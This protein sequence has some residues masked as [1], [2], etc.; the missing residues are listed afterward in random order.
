MSPAKTTQKEK[1]ERSK[2]RSS[3]ESHRQ[4]VENQNSKEKRANQP[5]WAN[6]Q[7]KCAIQLYAINKEKNRKNSIVYFGCVCVCDLPPVRHPF[8]HILPC[9]SYLRPVW[10]S[11]EHEI[12]MI[13][14]VLIQPYIYRLRFQPIQHINGKH[15]K[16]N[17]NTNTRA[18]KRAEEKSTPV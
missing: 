16:R 10:Q 2:R 7:K 8:E 12:R 14:G 18:N 1:N 4:S 6:L 15:L 3:A 17:R 13:P 5:S 11:N 9:P